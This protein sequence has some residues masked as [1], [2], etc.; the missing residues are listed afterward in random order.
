MSVDLGFNSKKNMKPVLKR[1]FGED[2][3]DR[4]VEEMLGRLETQV[5]ATI[6]NLGSKRFQCPQR[7]ADLLCGYCSFY[8]LLPIA[9]P[10]RARP[11]CGD[12]RRVNRLYKDVRALAPKYPDLAAD[13]WGIASKLLVES[14]WDEAATRRPAW[15]FT[16]AHGQLA[17]EL[18]RLFRFCSL[19]RR[20]GEIGDLVATTFALDD[21][22]RGRVHQVGSRERWIQQLIRRHR[23]R[24]RDISYFSDD[25]Q[26]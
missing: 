15:S 13:L 11:M 8:G 26:S 20:W 23:H 24:V 1:I 21:A 7:F 19:G 10:R 18:D 2:V 14:G 16:D 5:G 22:R 3:S 9:Y 17:V 25:F 4:S 12:I 6:A